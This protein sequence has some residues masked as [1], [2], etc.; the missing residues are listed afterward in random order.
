MNIYR[1]NF[2]LDKERDP[3][4]INGK[5]YIVT[6]TNTQYITKSAR[7]VLE[8]TIRIALN[9]INNSEEE[10]RSVSLEIKFNKLKI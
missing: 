6:E 1:L 5:K 8:S 9:A 3:I 10:I 7:S 2:E 4:T